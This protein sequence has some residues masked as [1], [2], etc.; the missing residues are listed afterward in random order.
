ME[1]KLSQAMGFCFGVKRAIEMTQD[2]LAKNERVYS[3]GPLIHNPQVMDRLSKEGLIV[4]N[5]VKEADVGVFIIRSHGLAPSVIREAEEKG[6]KIINAACP[7]VLAVHR[8]LKE[9]YKEGYEI[10]I[11]GDREHPEVKA[12]MGLIDGKA[13]VLEASQEFTDEVAPRSAAKRGETP[14]EAVPVAVPVGQSHLGARDNRQES[15]PERTAPLG[16]ERVALGKIGM[17][18]QTTQSLNRYLEIAATLLRSGNFQ[19]FRIYNTICEDVVKRQSCARDLLRCV[20]VMLVVGGEVS[21]NTRRLAE[22]SRD[23][24]VKTFHIETADE[25][26][27]AWLNPHDRVGVTSGASTP[28][29]IIDTVLEKLKKF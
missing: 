18:A 9:L 23:G 28:S 24:G 11:A 25:I 15:N 20:N 16:S 4:I 3:L 10:I 19:E 27:G 7:I 8:V 26:N 12:L 2:A 5:D 13:R 22:I 17:V 1:I 6:L 14:P 21:A 29:W